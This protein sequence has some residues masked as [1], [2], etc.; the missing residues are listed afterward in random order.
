MAYERI[1]NLKIE[2]ARILFRNFSGKEAKYN[3][4][5][6]RNFCVIIDD[7]IEAQRLADDGWNIRLL[8]PR[9]EGDEPS[10]YLPVAV[11]YHNVPPKVHIVQNGHPVMLT[12]DTIG[13]LDYADISNVDLIV[14]PYHWEV[15]GDSGIKAYLATMYVTIQEDP[16]AGKYAQF[17]DEFPMPEPEDLPFN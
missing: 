10:H 8:N 2:N 17:N 11:S 15:N 6:N 13:E 12:E 7:P 5:G 4:A 1:D 9:D 14:R 3:P 16:F